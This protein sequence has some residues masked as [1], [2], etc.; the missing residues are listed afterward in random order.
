MMMPKDRY[1]VSV[2]AAVRFW[3]YEVDSG[4]DGAREGKKH[5]GPTT[6]T[7]KL[8]PS[9]STTFHLLSAPLARPFET[10]FI[11]LV[12]Y[13]DFFSRFFSLSP[14]S[15]SRFCPTAASEH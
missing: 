1:T 12:I 5:A 2:K 8:S 4:G 10:L 7:R 15:V 13:A 14:P 9:I 3:A 6:V 11:K